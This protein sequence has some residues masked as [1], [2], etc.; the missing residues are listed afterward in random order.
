MVALSAG[1][2]GYQSFQAP[3]AFWN[4][5]FFEAP[6]Q[7]NVGLADL[8]NFRDMKFVIGIKDGKLAIGNP[9][10]PGEEVSDTDADKSVSEPVAPPEPPPAPEKAKVPLKPPSQE[11]PRESKVTEE[12]VQ[13]VK[14]AIRAE[15]IGELRACY[16]KFL[17]TL[18][19][20]AGGSME[21]KLHVTEYGVIDRV[22]NVPGKFD[23][24]IKDQSGR[25]LSKL[26]DC[27]GYKIQGLHVSEPPGGTDVLIPYPVTFSLPDN[28]QGGGR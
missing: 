18:H 5:D 9:A 20:R 8:L 22:V 28:W 21:F 27:I 4:N 11:P 10:G 15:R 25:T 7:V 1:A 6:P 2:V 24:T 12:Y 3:G 26:S 17:D 14:Q 19:S 16:M 13:Q 23:L